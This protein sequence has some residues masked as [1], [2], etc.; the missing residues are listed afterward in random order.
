MKQ[1]KLNRIQSGTNVLKMSLATAATNRNEENTK[2][3]PVKIINSYIRVMYM[4]KSHCFCNIHTPDDSP[5]SG[6]NY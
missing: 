4:Q 2:T 6:T 1:P 3:T 5:K